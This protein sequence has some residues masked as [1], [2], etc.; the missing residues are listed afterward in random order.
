M[1]VVDNAT[2]RRIDERCI[3][4]GSTGIEL[5]E[6]AGTGAVRLFLRNRGSEPG[7][8]VVACGRGNNGGDGLV[9]ARQLHLAGQ[10]VV[11]LIVGGERSPDCGANL[12]RARALGVEIVA[13]G[14]NP[15]ATLQELLSERPGRWVI[16]ALLGSGFA[17]PLREPLAALVA[18]IGESGRRVIA[19]DAPTGI[20]AD[21]GDADPATAVA[22]RTV[23]FGLPRQGMFRLPARQYCGRIELVDPGFDPG[24]VEEECARFSPVVEWIDQA[25]AVSRW[26]RRSIDAHKYRVG[27]LLVVGGSAGMSGAAALAA[28]AAHRIGAGIVE[29]LVPVPVAPVVDALTPES[30]VRGLAATER[31][32]FAAGLRDGILEHASGRSALVLGCGVGDH[33]DTAALMVELCAGLPRPAVI[34]AD[35]LNAFARTGDAPA[36]ASDCVLTPHAAEL[37]RLRGRSVADI[38]AD[39]FAASLD[40]AREL[41]AVVLLKGAPTIVAAPDGR[42][43]VV[44]SGGPE[45]ATAGSGDVLAGAI[46]G[47]LAAGMSTWDAATTG[48]FLHG[49][50]G[51]RLLGDRG[52]CGVI[53]GD[54]PLELARAGRE[55]EEAR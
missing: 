16:D 46:G 37:A 35:A 6:E 55:L 25:W 3:A 10:A 26:P 42:Q 22:E 20:N 29:V 1:Q 19:L 50:A 40:A 17:P 49:R 21:T 53:A 30:L 32:S 45:L 7:T 36:F 51:E 15:G 12:E 9:L 34:D 14:E 2:V 27:S 23:V 18:A 33:P 44:A 43:A 31:G 54:L 13:A 28:G 41:D 47:L 38:E 48:A 4:A 52:T 39:R 24:V 11:V 8:T 5:M